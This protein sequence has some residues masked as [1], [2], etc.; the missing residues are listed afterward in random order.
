LGDSALQIV[1]GDRFDPALNRRVL[2]LSEALAA[3]P[4][5]TDRVPAYASL[6][7]HYDP[8]VLSYG[9]LG[10]AVEPFLAATDN[11]TVASRRLSIPVCYG[12]EHGP[13][14]DAVARHCRLSPAEVIARHC[15]G[16][17][18][19]YFLG[20][21]PGFAYLGGLDPVLATPRHGTPRSS[22][23]AG[24]VGIAGAQ[25]GMYSLPSPGGWQ[26]I[27]RTP[28]HLFDPRRETPCLL[29]PRDELH[30]VPIG[31]EE[32]ARRSGEAAP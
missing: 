20:F 15:R 14:L 1:F 31:P 28:L 8:R 3:L 12:G 29:M 19:V 24:A 32:F 10:Q 17:Y 13:D 23:P 16:T 26:I 18:R 11:A 21:T 4:G 30:F 7:L 27:G 6:T 22:V 2:A 9:E 5:L 25:T